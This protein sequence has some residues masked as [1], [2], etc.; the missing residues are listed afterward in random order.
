MRIGFV[1]LGKMGFALAE[2]LLKA[3]H[4]LVVFN[5]T[6]DKAEP[7]ERAGARVADSVGGA[8]SDCEAA[9]TMLADDAA[10]EE[11]VFGEDGIA[12]SLPP[13]A[14][15]VS[16]STIS[17]AIARKLA[18]AHESRQQSYVSA[19]V[20]GRPDAAEAKRLLVI[21]AGDAS[22]VQRVRGL[23]DGLG[24]HTYVAGNEAWQAN[25]IKLNGN[26]MIACMMETFGETFATMRKAG[27]DHHLF[28]EIM[29]ELFGSPVYK[30]YGASIANE[31]FEPAAFA[32]KLG[33]KDIRLGLEAAGDLKVPMPFAS[34]LRDQFLVAMASGQEQMDWSSV[35]IVAARTSGAQTKTK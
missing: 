33:L 23:L 21:A 32:L 26:F 3:G 22:A 2:N 34:V 31:T 18:Q 12:A 1:G 5:R 35:G 4:E 6:R 19:P 27:V 14:V 7:L 8:V 9:F 30:S 20:F 11:V 15:H 28:Y 17:V 16:M 25:L 29:T 24:R 13:G 10:V